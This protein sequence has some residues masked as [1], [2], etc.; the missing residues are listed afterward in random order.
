MVQRPPSFLLPL[1]CTDMIRCVKGLSSV[2]RPLQQR[3]LGKGNTESN[4]TIHVTASQCTIVSALRA[5]VPRNTYD[6]WSHLHI[7][8]C[9]YDMCSH[10]HI[11]IRTC[12]P[13]LITSQH[14]HRAT[15]IVNIVP[16]GVPVNAACV[17]A[18]VLVLIAR[19]ARARVHTHDTRKGSEGGS[20]A[21]RV[22]VATSTA[23]T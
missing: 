3:L 23:T 15:H 2:A 14:L 10:L 11:H 22:C 17:P 13:C 7:H 18:C 4:H 5:P 6:M 12:D 16:P 8:I 9:A 19:T 20:G 21:V 1:H